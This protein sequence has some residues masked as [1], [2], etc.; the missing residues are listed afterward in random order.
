M[1]MTLS[2]RLGSELHVVH[3]GHVPDLYV[4][5]GSKVID[6]EELKGRIRESVERE[7]HESLEQEVRKI[8]AAGGEIKEAYARFGRVDKEII[9]LAGE[10][11]AE[12]V[13]L[14]SRGHDPI[15]LAVMG[16]VSESVV[17]YA[18]CPVLVVR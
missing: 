13:I 15:K 7:T 18:P 10:L 8:K 2:D 4:S 12:L 14:G 3:M 1:A 5:P 11:N 17:R 9:H 16:S 6:P